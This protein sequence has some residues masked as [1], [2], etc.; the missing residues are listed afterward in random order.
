MNILNKL[1]SMLL[2]FDF[3]TIHGKNKKRCYQI[4]NLINKVI[5]RKNVPL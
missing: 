5:R 4:T 2:E 3:L 1:K